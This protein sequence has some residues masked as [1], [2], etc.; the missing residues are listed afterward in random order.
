MIDGSKLL[1]KNGTVVLLDDT[2]TEITTSGGII[3]DKNALQDKIVKGKILSIAPFLL[4][5][6]SWKNPPFEVGDEVVYGYHAGAG[7][8]WTY[9]RQLTDSKLIVQE[10]YR[11][12]KW[13]EVMATY[14]K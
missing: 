1:A 11:L 12:V 4:E 2:K 13:T 5:D 14:V 6:G 7:S 10:T 3:L 8:V 9:D